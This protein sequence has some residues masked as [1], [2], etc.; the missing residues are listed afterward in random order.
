MPK[1]WA[2]SHSVRKRARAALKRENRPCWICGIAIDY[3]LPAVHPFS[4]ELDH[5]KPID[6]FP[7][8]AFVRSNWAPAHRKCNRAK[9]NSNYAPIIR[10]SGALK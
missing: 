1:E 9:S 3:S 10:R 4:F 7:D 6:R 2:N 5:I 8:L